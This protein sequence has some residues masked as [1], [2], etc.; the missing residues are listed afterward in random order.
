M[1]FFKFRK[2]S[3]D[4]PAPAP[5][6]E[7]VETMR[8][9]ARYRLVG[10]SILVLAGV[11]GFPVLFDNQPRPISVDIPIEIPDKAKVQAPVNPENVAKAGKQGVEAS[12]PT[13]AP[14]TPTPSPATTTAPATA[15]APAANLS[16]KR[17]ASGIVAPAAS[18]AEAKPAKPVQKAEEIIS[19][20]AA[21][22]AND[23]AKAQA[24]LDN[25]APA[26]ATRYVVQFGAFSDAT[27]AHETRMKV[28]KAGIK[29]YAQMVQGPDGKKFRVRVGPF[30]TKAE[31]MKAAEKIKK[32]DLPVS[33][34][35]L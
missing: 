9:R 4:H 33:I 27:K 14:V 25:T 1:A 7:S 19:P 16:E 15:A 13:V 35:E 6:T 32:L 8:R 22:K 23:G 20:P 5:V 28:E 3:D 29:T 12:A 26:S 18:A 2:D 21:V 11:I 17:A 10:A 30:D 24:L 34:L 31:A